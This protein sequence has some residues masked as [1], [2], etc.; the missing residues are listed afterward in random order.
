MLRAI[1]MR[2]GLLPS[3][4]T[5]APNSGP[6]ATAPSPSTPNPTTATFSPGSKAALR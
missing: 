5:R 3:A 6:S 2:T 1:S 4:T